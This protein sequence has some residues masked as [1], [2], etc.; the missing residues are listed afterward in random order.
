[1]ELNR[2]DQQENQNQGSID[3]YKYRYIIYMDW[4]IYITHLSITID[5]QSIPLFDPPKTLLERAL[6]FPLN[7]K[8]LV[9]SNPLLPLQLRIIQAPVFRNHP[10]RWLPFLE[11]P[12]LPASA[13]AAAGSGHHDIHNLPIVLRGGGSVRCAVAPQILHPTRVWVGLVIGV[14]PIIIIAEIGAVVAVC[15]VRLHWSFVSVRLGSEILHFAA[16]FSSFS[17]LDR[18]WLNSQRVCVELS[19]AVAASYK[20]VMMVRSGR[21][22]IIVCYVG[23]IRI[24]QEKTAHHCKILFFYT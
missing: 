13:S 2:Q 14:D 21:L 16:G 10:I 24:L 23:G 11:L 4:W 15:A 5:H 12:L 8:S 9:A 17:F 3:T 20:H 19:V 1:M 6:H 7:C 22:C 18:F